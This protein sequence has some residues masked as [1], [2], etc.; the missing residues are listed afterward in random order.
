MTHPQRKM[1]VYHSIKRAITSQWT[2]PFSSDGYANYGSGNQLAD[3]SPGPHGFANAN[4]WV[5]LSKTINKQQYQFCLQTDGYMG[6]RLKYSKLGFTSKTD[7]LIHAPSA[8]DQEVL[9]GSGTD[10]APVYQQILGGVLS[11]NPAN[12]MISVESTS[13]KFNF[14]L[15]PTVPAPKMPAPKLIINKALK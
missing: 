5:I 14:T 3:D 10:S 15:R 1:N 4:A 11:F 13:T 9:L 6:V 12:V 7:S 8:A 2:I